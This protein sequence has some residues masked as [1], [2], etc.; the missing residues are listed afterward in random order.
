MKV[1]Q[2]VEIPNVK[3]YS[4]DKIGGDHLVV[5]EFV[6]D[7][8]GHPVM[9]SCMSSCKELFSVVLHMDKRS[10]FAILVGTL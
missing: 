4:L 3:T 10:Y 9:K 1:L 2:A 8:S 5:G 6:D 7:L